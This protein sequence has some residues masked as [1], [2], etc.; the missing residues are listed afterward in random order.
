M[1]ED[2]VSDDRPNEPEPATIEPLESLPLL[3]GVGVHARALDACAEL[4]T[5]LDAASA[6]VPDGVAVLVAIHPGSPGDEEAEA[7]LSRSTRWPVVRVPA[8]T[9]E[10]KG[11]HVYLLPGDEGIAASDGKLVATRASSK[12]RMPI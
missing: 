5:S 1:S 9:L 4:L 12:P 3:I 7:K 11:K 8:G 10:P 2:A 6:S